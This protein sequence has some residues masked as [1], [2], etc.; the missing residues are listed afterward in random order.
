MSDSDVEILH[1]WENDPRLK[2]YILQ[3]G[4][5]PKKMKTLREVVHSTYDYD[6]YDFRYRDCFA[7]MVVAVASNKD[8]AIYLSGWLKKKKKFLG[9]ST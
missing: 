9:Y 5:I 6:S 4:G 1:D 7:F 3:V 2:I 8:A